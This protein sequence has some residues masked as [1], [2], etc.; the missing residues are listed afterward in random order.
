M[1]DIN[2]GFTIKCNHCEEKIEWNEEY[3]SNKLPIEVGCD[4]DANSWVYCKC[5]NRVDGY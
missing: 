3:Y 4:Y 1:E 5:G 2:V